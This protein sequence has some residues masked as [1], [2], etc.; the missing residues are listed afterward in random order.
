VLLLLVLSIRFAST[1][2]A[3]SPHIVQPGAK[4]ALELPSGGVAA[5]SFNVCAG[6]FTELRIEQL[7]NVVSA[8]LHLPGVPD[9][10]PSICDAGSHSVIH[11]PFVSLQAANPEV[12]LR[13]GKANPASI[14]VTLAPP[15]LATPADSDEVSLYASLAAAEQMRRAPNQDAAKTLAAY[16]Q[17]ITFSRQSANTRVEQLALLGQAR[18]YL[19]AKGDY[20]AGLK[21]ANQAIQLADEANRTAAPEDTVINAA[22]WKVLSSAYSFLARYPAMLDA[23]RHSLALY[24][25]L[26]DLYWQGILE[27]NAANVYLETGDL[28]HALSSAENALI[29][30]RQM[31]DEQGIAFTEASIATIHQRRGEYQAAFDANQAALDSIRRMP[32]PDEEGQ[33][34]LNLAEIYDDLNDSGG[35]RGALDKALPLLEQNHDAANQSSALTDLGL[36]ELRTGS[37]GHAASAVDHALTLARTQQLPREQ[38]LALLAQAQLLAAK[39]RFQPALAS[40]Q[41]GRALA[42]KAGEAATVAQ[43]LQ[44][45]GDIRA[46]RGDMD[47][48]LAA[49]TAAQSAWSQIPN[50]EHI[51]LAQASRARIEFGSGRLDQAGI[52]IA[53]ALDGFEASRSNIAGR[54][55]RQS[56]FASVHDF[57]DLAIEIAMRSAPATQAESET[58]AREGFAI[59]E[60]ARARSLMDAVRSAGVA[61]TVGVSADAIDRAADLEHQIGAEM[62]NILRLG[63][64]ADSPVGN[65]RPTRLS[66]AKASLH[67]LVLESDEAESHQRKSAALGDSLQ[68]PTIN[69]IRKSLL[70]PDTVL[71]EY[72]EGGRSIWL[73]MVTNSTLRTFSLPTAQV[74]AAVAAFHRAL[75]AREQFPADEDLATRNA[76]IAREDREADRDAQMLSRLLLPVAL[77]ASVHRLIVVPD[78]ELASVPF[79]A[80][81]QRGGRFLIQD[82]E[83]ASEPS[84]SVALALALRPAPPVADNIAVFADPVYS[85][86][87]ARLTQTMAVD[88]LSSVS[89]QPA[90]LRSDGDLDMTDLPRLGG[91]LREANAIALIAGQGRTRLFLGFDASVQKA[92]ELDWH[93]VAVAHFATHAIVDT[94]LPELSG[95]ILS[96]FNAQGARQD[97]VLWLHDIYRTPI[98]VPLVVL[99]GCSTA[100]GKSLPGEGVT[101]LSQ[102]FLSSGASAVIGTLWTVDDTTSDLAIANFYSAILKN[103]Q[104]LSAGMRAAQLQMI[105]ARRPTYDWAGYIV[106]GNWRINLRPSTH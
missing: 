42:R 46:R 104:S 11:I 13:A 65:D 44:A 53:S 87:D 60:R 21:S 106:Q 80:L 28:D 78:G 47:G 102:A 8:T 20:L 95:I 6:C 73:W 101:G 22:T 34:W 54:S 3:Q 83:I 86:T 77:P 88:A 81:R 18:V 52:D 91:S 79:A 67:A 59:A 69:D 26:G 31:S 36:L 62:Q 32:Y 82:Y 39:G 89:A 43:M 94:A 25:S 99:S 74:H 100:S 75:L 16:D 71:L 84:A 97:G 33:V 2:F 37:L 61:S 90:I 41:D 58:H 63:S 5:I 50:P 30:A 105:N 76:R 93:S 23:T 24:K 35:E 10:R 17:A 45:E 48:A 57:Y 70:G 7:H 85:S 56:Y 4:L 12:E 38:S 64:S 40:L 66:Q 14:V 29:I 96:N 92:I 51:A 68:P 103:G 55:L 1:L 72:W 27:G 15:R 98:P 9:S 19:Y 49:Y